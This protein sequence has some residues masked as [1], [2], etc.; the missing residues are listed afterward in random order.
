MGQYFMNQKE[1]QINEA[2]D[3]FLKKYQLKEGYT[4]MRIATIWNET[5]GKMIAL[6]TKKVEL[7]NKRLIVYISSP[8]VKNE[9]KMLKSDIIAKIN[10]KAGKEIITEIIIR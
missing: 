3:E 9:L 1:Y 2:I 10:E 7:D 6:S 5:L 4:R 8:I